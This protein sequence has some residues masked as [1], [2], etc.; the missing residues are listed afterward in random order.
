MI[1]MTRESQIILHDALA[2]PIHERAAV[3][4]ELL[5]SLDGE[6]DPDAEIAWAA[7]LERRAL[8]VLSGESQGEDWEVVHERIRR[9]LGDRPK[10]E[11][12]P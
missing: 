6:P 4:A 2:L 7:E 1:S 12:Q 8:R 11:A 10:P 9:D 5:A 3:A